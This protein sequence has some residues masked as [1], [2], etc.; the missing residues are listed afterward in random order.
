MWSSAAVVHDTTI[1]PQN[2]V[3][4]SMWR[5]LATADRSCE[6]L[7]TRKNL[8]HPECCQLPQAFAGTDPTSLHFARS[9]AAAQRAFWV[10]YIGP[11]ILDSEPRLN[12]LA[13]GGEGAIVANLLPAQEVRGFSTPGD[14]YLRKPT[15]NMLP[16]H[17]HCMRTD[18]KASQRL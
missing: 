1:Q 6:P 15:A 14:A 8:Q 4:A 9:S 7:P 10:S 18:G 2:V 5:A 13:K 17:V 16:W 3:Q 11:H 12:F